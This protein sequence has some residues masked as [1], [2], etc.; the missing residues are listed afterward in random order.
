M[1]IIIIEEEDKKEDKTED[2]KIITIIIKI[3]IICKDKSD[4]FLY[5]LISDNYNNY[6]GGY[7]R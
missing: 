3:I 6:R 4:Y 7:Q 1:E 2:I 5:K